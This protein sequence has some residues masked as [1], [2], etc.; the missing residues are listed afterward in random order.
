MRPSFLNDI[1]S[2][3]K[4]NK[5]K[6]NTNKE[7]S[8]DKKGSSQLVPSQEAITHALKNLKKTAI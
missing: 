6:I 8:S 4:L 1:S 5:I 2:G 3:I 7:T